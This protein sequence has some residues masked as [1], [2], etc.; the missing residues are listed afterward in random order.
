MDINVLSISIKKG[1]L[2][3][4]YS[5][6]I[7]DDWDARAPMTYHCETSYSEVV[8]LI[9]HNQK[10]NT[11]WKYVERIKD[12]KKALEEDYNISENTALEAYD[13]FI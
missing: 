11:F 8:N 4:N 1:E 9:N 10:L 3:Y 2:F 5:E 12:A 7:H 6:T 13:K